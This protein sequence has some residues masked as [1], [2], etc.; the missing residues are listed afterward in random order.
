MANDKASTDMIINA[1]GRGAPRDIVDK[2]QNILNN[3]GSPLD[4]A[5]TLGEHAGDYLKNELLRRQ[6]DKTKAE[7]NKISGGVSNGSKE[8]VTK[9]GITLIKVTPKEIQD[10]NDTQIAK[11]SLVSL[12]DNMINSIEKYGTQVLFGEEAG[13][14]SGAKT[15]LL[16]AMKNL[17]KTGALDKGTIDVLSGTIPDSEFFATES[18]Q[19]AAL[20][21]LKDTIVNKTDEY[22]NSY[23]GTTAETDPRTKRI[24]EKE[25]TNIVIPSGVGSV[26][27]SYAQ[28][29]MGAL[30]NVNNQIGTQQSYSGYDTGVKN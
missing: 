5:K 10:L 18:A 22:I 6:I 30:N 17:E 14:R 20:Q 4:V 13:T 2:A 9:N 28:S 15:N 23:K 25:G 19:K 12:V 1:R 24:Y 3:G 29:T 7:A 27:A 16:L 21:Q 8:L 11:N 26:S